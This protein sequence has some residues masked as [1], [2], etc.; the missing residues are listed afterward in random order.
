MNSYFIILPLKIIYF[1]FVCAAGTFGEEGVNEPNISQ[2][3]LD[4]QQ[5]V[6]VEVFCILKLS[7]RD[8]LIFI[9]SNII[10]D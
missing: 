4:N 1:I 7:I 5:Q 8:I 9:P 3:I 10:N 2:S 6:Q